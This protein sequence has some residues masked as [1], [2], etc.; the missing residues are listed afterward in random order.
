MSLGCC[1]R[2]KIRIPSIPEHR[3]E[4]P[5]RKDSLGKEKTGR[6]V[7]FERESLVSFELDL[8]PESR[9]RRDRVDEF[10]AAEAIRAEEAQIH[11]ACT[12]LASDLSARGGFETAQDRV[13][14]P[15]GVICPWCVA[16]TR[17]Q[18][19][20]APFVMFDGRVPEA[21]MLSKPVQECVQM[22]TVLDVGLRDLR[23]RDD[24]PVHQ[25]RGKKPEYGSGAVGTGKPAG[26]VEE[27]RVNTG[28]VVGKK[29]IPDSLICR[30]QGNVRQVEPDDEVAAQG[31]A[32]NDQRTRVSLL[33]QGIPE[34]H[35]EISAGL[36]LRRNICPPGLEQV[37]EEPERK[38]PAVLPGLPAVPMPSWTVAFM[39]HETVKKVDVE[40]VETRPVERQP[41][42]DVP[43]RTDQ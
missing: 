26:P 29:A 33:F 32:P 24:T 3:S 9:D 38:S 22:F 2:G 11:P 37:P 5:G 7:S 17:K 23:R 20:N 18:R 19:A 39:A 35:R 31:P 13:P 12:R 42:R 40:L 25:E 4:M 21:A 1:N 28:T 36:D 16:E 43:G 34:L 10:R 41:D 30:R 27:P 15:G 6:W 8:T 14:D